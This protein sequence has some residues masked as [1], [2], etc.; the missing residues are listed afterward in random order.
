MK[1]KF[2]S[3]VKELANKIRRNTPKTELYLLGGVLSSS[4][5]VLGFTVYIGLSKPISPSEREFHGPEIP[6]F[7]PNPGAP[8][9]TARICDENGDGIADALV[10]DKGAILYT[11]DWNGRIRND[12]IRMS[13]EMRD[14][15]S[16]VMTKGRNLGKEITQHLYDEHTKDGRK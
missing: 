10:M 2:I 11:D 5:A 7:Y 8:F 14:D 15:A 4:V 3:E 1:E 6:F 9:T 12:A 13:P 16:A